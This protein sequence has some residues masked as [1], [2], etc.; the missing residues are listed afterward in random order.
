MTLELS[1][2]NS[3]GERFTCRVQVIPISAA[4]PGSTAMLIMEAVKDGGP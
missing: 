3:A 4:Q 1:A 2:V